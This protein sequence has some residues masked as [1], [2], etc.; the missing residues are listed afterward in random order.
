MSTT[1]PLCERDYKT[2]STYKRSNQREIMNHTDSQ[3]QNS[4]IKIKIVE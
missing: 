2:I 1:N 3:A 4:P